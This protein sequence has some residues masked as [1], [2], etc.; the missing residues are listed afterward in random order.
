MRAIADTCHG[1]IAAGAT[2]TFTIDDGV[3][4]QS[5]VG[6]GHDSRYSSM[7]VTGTTT[8]GNMSYTLTLYPTAETQRSYVTNTRVVTTAGAR[9]IRSQTLTT[10]RSQSSRVRCCI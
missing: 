1:R 9:G 7:G 6:D 8:L 2:F 4:S 5:Q 3:V 10:R